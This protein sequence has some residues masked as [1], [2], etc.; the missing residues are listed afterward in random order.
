[1]ESVK[2]LLLPALSGQG[3]L[4]K[5]RGLCSLGWGP[6]GGRSG[7]AQYRYAMELCKEMVH[8]NWTQNSSDLV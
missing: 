1:M 6:T 7:G 2:Q 4:Q 3:C 5:P 8:V